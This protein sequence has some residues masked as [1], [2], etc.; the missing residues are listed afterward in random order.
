MPSFSASWCA[1]IAPCSEPQVPLRRLLAAWVCLPWERA[2][3]QRQRGRASQPTGELKAPT[4]M[5]TAAAS[6]RATPSNVWS[7]WHGACLVLSLPAV[8]WLCPWLANTCAL[9]AEQAH[10]SKCRWALHE[11]ASTLPGN[12]A[13]VLKQKRLHIFTHRNLHH[14]SVLRS[15][16]RLPKT[17]A[18]S[19]PCCAAVAFAVLVHAAAGGCPD[20][21][22]KGCKGKEALHPKV[23]QGRI[24]GRGCNP[25]APAAPPAHVPPPLPQ[26]TTQPARS[27]DQAGPMRNKQSMKPPT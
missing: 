20:D 17:A 12:A 15:G 26:P 25:G 21:L 13:A 7:M 9:T 18:E 2:T 22:Q 27:A 3:Q 11:M 19:H 10:S 24:V 16:H 6:S 1:V 8:W 5:Q 4:L 23:S 14:A